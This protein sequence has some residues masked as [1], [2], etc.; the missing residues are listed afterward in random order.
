MLFTKALFVVSLTIELCIGMYSGYKPKTRAKIP[1]YKYNPPPTVRDKES[2]SK[3]DSN[4]KDIKIP[5]EKTQE[6]KEEKGQK[7]FG[8]TASDKPPKKDEWV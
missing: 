8:K 2:S 4:G 7:M 3:G 1:K 5:Q 6:K